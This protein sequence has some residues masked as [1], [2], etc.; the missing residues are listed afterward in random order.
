M[1]SAGGATAPRI[2]ATRPGGHPG[3]GE[4]GLQVSRHQTEGVSQHDY[5][6]HRPIGTGKT[7]AT[8][9]PQTASIAPVNRRMP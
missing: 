9:Q 8:R 1:S 3:R 2:S 7:S 6:P 4:R 5:S